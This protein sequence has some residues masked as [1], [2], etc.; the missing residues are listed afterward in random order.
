MKTQ[1]GE[2]IE[3][4][5]VEEIEEILQR[6]KAEALREEDCG[7]IMQLFDSF[8]YVTQL[9]ESKQTT[10]EE[11]RDL[12]VGAK[13]EKTRD[14]FGTEEK[15]VEDDGSDAEP[16]TEE[17]G[18]QGQENDG[19]GKKKRKNHGRNGAD[20]YE[21]AEQIDVPHESLEPGA[22]CPDPDCKGK[23]YRL[24]KPK[25]IVRVTGAAPLRATVHRC[26]RLRCNLCGTVFTAKAPEGIGEGKYDETSASMIALLKYGSGVPFNRLQRLEQNLGIPLPA[27][28]Q[29]EIVYRAAALIRV[30]Y[31]HLAFI[32]AQGKVLHND[33]T[34]A[35]ILE[36]LD[37]REGGRARVSEDENGRTGV[38]TSGIVSVSDGCRIALFFTGRKHAGENLQDVL[39]ERSPEL[40]PPIQMA[41]ALSRNTCGE[42]ATIVANCIAHA[43]RQFV[44]V[45][46]NFPV[47]CRFVLETLGEVYKNDATARERAL[48]PEERME[49]HRSESWPHI[50]ELKKWLRRQF[51]ERLVEPNSGLGKAISYMLKHWKKLTMFLRTPGAPLDN[52][53]CERVL[54]KAIL[55]RRNSLFYKT[56][57]GARVGDLFMSLIHTAELAGENPLDYLN[58]LQRHPEEIAQAPGDWMPWNYRDTLAALA[59]SES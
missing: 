56:E 45:V 36:F 16:M 8:L 6:A 4:L 19:E 5:K 35:T 37:K 54:K 46:E 14:L 41:D 57:N 12:L 23:V 55:H 25:V 53:L 1:Q 42:F 10:I 20:A 29:W 48:S 13:S 2:Q 3:V 18:T 11:L 15:N 7:K 39:R 38:F 22:P 40:A 59:T 34:G 32:A 43:R 30:V 27:A 26:E 33:D 21:G 24:K 9:V 28:T 49:F 47:E 44:D 51:K 50:K 17:D 52:N 31:L 58:E